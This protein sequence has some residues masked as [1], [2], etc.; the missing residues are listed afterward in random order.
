M[1][2]KKEK[3]IHVLLEHQIDKCVECYNTF[4]NFIRNLNADSKFESIISMSKKISELES[5]AD[6]LRRKIIKELLVSPLLPITRREIKIL[7]EKND[8]IA[9]KSEEIIKQIMLQNVKF[10]KNTKELIIKINDKTKYQLNLLKSLVNKVFTDF[11]KPL[12]LH[13]EI[14]LIE[15]IETE[16]DYLEQSAIKTIYNSDYELAYKNQIKNF[17]SD[18]AEIS[19]II[20]DISDILEMIIVMRKV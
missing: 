2:F 4:T 15:K 10:D 13:K 5:E 7:I 16:V 8:K 1:F 3:D 11:S 14:E 6:T 19:D 18:F 17:I 12:D 20:E 9:N